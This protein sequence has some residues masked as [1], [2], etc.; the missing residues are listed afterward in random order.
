MNL[1]KIF[2]DNMRGLLGDEFDDYK[3]CLDSPMHHGIRINTSKISVE[4]LTTGS[5]MGIIQSTG[6]CLTLE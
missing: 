2:E 3:A 1:P 6:K 4:D 5:C